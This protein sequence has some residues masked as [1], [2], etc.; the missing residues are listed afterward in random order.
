MAIRVSFVCRCVR[1]PRVIARFEDRSV[2]L[3]AEVA[4]HINDPLRT[5]FYSRTRP[6]LGWSLGCRTALRAVACPTPGALAPVRGIMSRSLFAY[7]A[8]SAPP[9]GTS[10]FRGLSAYLQGL[11]LA[12]ALLRPHGGSGLSLACLC[13]HVVFSAPAEPIGCLYPVPSPTAQPSPCTVRPGLSGPRGLLRSGFQRI[14]FPPRRRVFLRWDGVALLSASGGWWSGNGT[15]L[16]LMPYNWPLSSDPL[17][18]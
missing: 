7:S 5:I 12:G 4:S 13:T 3:G 9:S 10:S 18:E 17:L 15:A 14:G 6:A 2:L 8:P 16:F 11:C 1:M